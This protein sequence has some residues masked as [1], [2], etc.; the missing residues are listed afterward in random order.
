MRTSLRL[1]SGLGG[2]LAAVTGVAAASDPPAAPPHVLPIDRALLDDPD[3]ILQIYSQQPA[4]AGR[5]AADPTA[6]ARCGGPAADP[7][8]GGRPTVVTLPPAAPF[9]VGAIPAALWRR[10]PVSDP[11]WRLNFLALRWMNPLARR[12]AMDGQTAS[13]A[14]LVAQAVRFHQQN[15]D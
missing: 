15:P 9:T 8:P 10:P 1:A 11:T 13:L 6:D 14:A 5:L 3:A 2:L 7:S 4:P 12:A